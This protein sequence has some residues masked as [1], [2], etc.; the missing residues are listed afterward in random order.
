MAGAVLLWTAGF[1]IIYACQ[2][3]Q[4]DVE[5]GLF[6]VPSKVGI[7]AAL[8]IARLTHLGCVALLVTLGFWSEALGM[9]YFIGVGAAVAL[10]IVEHSLV[11][12]TDLSK[13]GLAFFTVNG[14]ISLLLGTLGIIDVFV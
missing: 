3:Y 6:S 4:V 13:V 11:K 2:D 5:A 7:P 10:L 14:I 1:D 9:L 12:P 8:W